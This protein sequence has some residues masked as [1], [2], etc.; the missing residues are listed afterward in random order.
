ML[1]RIGS[2]DT[3]IEVYMTTMVVNFG[4]QWIACYNTVTF[5]S[6]RGYVC[7]RHDCLNSSISSGG[8]N[9]TNCHEVYPVT[10]KN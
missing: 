8:T 7:S 2:R 3:S 6:R 1:D 5:M 4:W 9:F 10:C